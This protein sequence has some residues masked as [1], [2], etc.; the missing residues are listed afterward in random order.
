[1]ERSF[2][3]LEAIAFDDIGGG[4]AQLR[5]KRG[6]ENFVGFDRFIPLSRQLVMLYEE[7]GDQGRKSSAYLV[8]VVDEFVVHQLSSH[9]LASLESY[10]ITP[11]PDEVTQDY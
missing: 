8:R 1:M 7:V 10:T 5:N 11:L 2:D 6:Q 9:F 4:C 3:R